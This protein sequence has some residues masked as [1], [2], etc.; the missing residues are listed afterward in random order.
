MNFLVG[1]LIVLINIVVLIFGSYTLIYY[2]ASK[3]PQ[4]QFDKKIFPKA[5]LIIPFYNEEKTLKNK[6]KN[7]KEIDYK[8]DRLNILFVNDHS[9]DNSIKIIKKETKNFPF[10]CNIINNENSQGK[11]NALNYAFKK[12]D[13]EITI[14]TDADCLMDK[15]SITHL[16]QNFQNKK[17]G[18]VC[19]RMVMAKPKNDHLT[20]SKEINYRFFYDIW[21]KGES[22][23]DSISVC[24][25]ALMAFKT[26]LIKE[27][28]LTSEVDDT[29]L[30]FKIIKKG[31]KIQ[32][33]ND[34]IVYEV[35]PHK[36]S[37]R[38]KQKMRRIRESFSS[39][40]EKYKEQVNNLRLYLKEAEK[41]ITQLEEEKNT[42]QKSNS[43]K[44][45]G[46]NFFNKN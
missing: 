26:D 30:I 14:I 9:S 23:I 28:I 31:F 37:E 18:G 12:I 15:E 42:K 13:S 19:A 2:V 29:E 25:G 5:T 6:I 11:S 38:I 35:V 16:A 24:N 20:Y 33:E 8:R 27:A 10:K 39:D 32:Y 22:N 34:A 3:K 41:R 40:I 43:K 17:I 45:S 7:L 1:L 46:F 21:R 4:K 36:H 44:K